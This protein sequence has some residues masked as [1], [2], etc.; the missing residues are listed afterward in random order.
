M[1]SDAAS[2]IFDRYSDS[3]SKMFLSVEIVQLLY[4]ER[5]ISKKTLHE[6]ENLQ[7][8]LADS[9]LAALCTTLSKHPYQLRVFA[10]IL[11]HSKK[12]VPI[13]KEMF[14][15]YGNNTKNILCILTHL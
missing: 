5:V 8:S 11:L 2:L 10:A 3:L 6:I 15:D 9:P 7:G 4:T 1:K 12:T 13:A 14:K